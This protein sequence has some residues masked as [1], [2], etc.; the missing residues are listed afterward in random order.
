MNHTASTEDEELSMVL[1]RAL[2]SPKQEGQ[3]NHIFRS[4]CSVDNKVCTLIVDGGSCE[5]FV[6]QKLVDNLKLST[7]KHTDP[8]MLGCVK[9]GSS[10]KVTEACKIPLSI[11]KHYKHEIWCDVIDM[12]ASLVLLGRPWQFDV[13]ATHKGVIMCLSLN[14]VLIKLLLLLLINLENLKNP[15]LR[16]QIF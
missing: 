11:G 5:N 14:G 1:H 13:D 8:Y 2:L 7:K 9:K 16:V 15:K 12:D 10:V 3:R 4:L 6:S